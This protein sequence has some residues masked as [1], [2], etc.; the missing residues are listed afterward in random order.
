MLGGG[1]ERLILDRDL[2]LDGAS[3]ERLRGLLARRAAHEP[4]AYIL[5]RREFRYLTLTVDGEC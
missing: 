1:R 3:T 4:I 2:P 5:G